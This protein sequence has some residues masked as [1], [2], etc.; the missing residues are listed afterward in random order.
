MPT[1]A[2]H[3]PPDPPKMRIDAYAVQTFVALASRSQARKAIKAGTLLINGK[4]C[5]SAWFVRPGDNLTLTLPALPR[6]PIMALSLPIV[7]LDPWMAIVHKPAGL[8]VRGNHARTLVRALPHNFPISPLPDALPQP[9]PVHRLDRRTSGLV[10]VA[11]TASSRVALGHMLQKQAITKEYRA[12]VLGKLTGSGTITIPVEG[13]SAA[14]RW[15]ALTHTRTLHGEW[16]TTVVAWPETGRTHQIR[17]HLLH[18]GHPILGDGLYHLDHVLRGGGLFLCAISISM[19]HPQ[20]NEPLKVA[21]ST[22]SKFTTHC[23][24]EERRWH[25]HQKSTYAV[26]EEPKS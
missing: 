15:Q 25:N 8:H 7:H 5:S 20:T 23:Q 24:R 12:I 10:I 11:R 6:L 22:P 17:R 21:I 2:H 4:P 1:Y 16:L 18:L 26:S 9:D 13:R 19:N 3:I 14:T